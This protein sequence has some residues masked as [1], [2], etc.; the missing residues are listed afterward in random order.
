MA[1]DPQQNAR[2]LVQFVLKQQNTEQ[3]KSWRIENCSG[4]EDITVSCDDL[5][6]SRSPFYIK[7]GV[8]FAFY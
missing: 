3:Q 5:F 1:K 4:S 7:V 8:L 2:S 6:Q